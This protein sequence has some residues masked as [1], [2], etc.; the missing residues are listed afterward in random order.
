MH[1]SLHLALQKIIMCMLCI[2]VR[3]GT[4]R[5]QGDALCGESTVVLLYCAA[6]CGAIRVRQ[7]PKN[8]ALLFELELFVDSTMTVPSG[9]TEISPR[10]SY[11]QGFSQFLGISCSTHPTRGLYSLNKLG[12]LV[13]IAMESCKKDMHAVGPRFVETGVIYCCRRI[14]GTEHLIVSAGTARSVRQRGVEN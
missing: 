11:Q 4:P 9:K 1:S 7:S 14:Q 6:V 10:S 3:R 12:A 2:S 5:K 13:S 8:A